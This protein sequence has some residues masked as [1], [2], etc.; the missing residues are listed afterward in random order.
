MFKYHVTK[1]SSNIYNIFCDGAGLLLQFPTEVPNHNCNHNPTQYKNI[2][3]N[4]LFSFVLVWGKGD[5]NVP[6]LALG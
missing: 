2:L 5:S 4:A 3:Y 1:N 6:V